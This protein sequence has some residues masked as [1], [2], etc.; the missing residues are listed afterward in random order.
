MLLQLIALTIPPVVVLI[1]LLKRS[2]NLE[3]GF[4]KLSFGLVFA[5]IGLLIAGA[6]SILVYFVAALQLPVTMYAALILVILGLCPFAVFVGVM[7]HEHR[8]E[9]GP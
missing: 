2:E 8:A 7:Y 5:S 3:W 6:M 1:E 9:H 4:R